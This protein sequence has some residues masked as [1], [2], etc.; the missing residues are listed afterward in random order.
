MAESVKPAHGF[1][2]IVI[3]ALLNLAAILVLGQVEWN[4]LNTGTYGF[5]LGIAG[6]VHAVEPGGP[7][8][9]AGIAVGDRVDPSPM[10]PR[11][12]IA[13]QYPTAGVP[14]ALVVRRNGVAR[15]VV[16]TAAPSPPEASWSRLFLY[17]Y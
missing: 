13:A 11:D 14:I 3:L 12:R 15:T 2:R 4:V 5:T 7:A 6:G 10:S 16:L 9:K 1:R 17:G 8:E